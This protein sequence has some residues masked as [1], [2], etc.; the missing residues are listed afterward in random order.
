VIAAPSTRLTTA[1]AAR[2]LSGALVLS[3]YTTA[4]SVTSLRG[5]SR[6]R[7]AD[8]SSPMR[9]AEERAAASTSR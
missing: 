2:W 6:G 7:R 9:A 4:A 3:G 8:S 5:H 1:V